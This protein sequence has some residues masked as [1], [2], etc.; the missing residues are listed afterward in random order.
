MAHVLEIHKALVDP[1][2]AEAL[3]ALRPRLIEAVRANVPGFVSATLVRVDERTWID[4]IEWE[5]DEARLAAPEIEMQLPEARELT[6]LIKEP[7]SSDV[8][9]IAHAAR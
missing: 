6:A 3:I 1:E 5:S 4:L 7:L 2:K 9:E 8:G